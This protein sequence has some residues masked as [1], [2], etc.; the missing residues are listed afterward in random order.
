MVLCERVCLESEEYKMG[1]ISVD[2]YD[3]VI[4]SHFSIL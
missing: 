4:I 3:P 1:N 2:V